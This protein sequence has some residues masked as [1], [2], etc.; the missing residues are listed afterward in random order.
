MGH[1][2]HHVRVH[3]DDAAARSATAVSAAAYTVGPHVMFA[4]GQ[5]NP[6]SAR[7]RSLIAHEVVHTIQQGASL[8][9]TVQRLEIGPVDDPLEREADRIAARIA[10]ADASSLVTGRTSM[11]QPG[12]EVVEEETSE[13]GQ[14][15]VPEE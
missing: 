14:E 5:W 15:I 8:P 7:G 4:A 3:A 11:L 9:G 12:G 10:G 1:S 13:A 2:L 6:S